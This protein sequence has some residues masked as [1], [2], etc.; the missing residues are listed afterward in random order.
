MFGSGLVWA[1]ENV[2]AGVRGSSNLASL[3]I[4]RICSVILYDS[5]CVY[6][7]HT[8]ELRILRQIVASYMLRLSMIVFSLLCTLNIKDSTLL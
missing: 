7:N 5:R 2:V 8:C 6:D 3:T 1:R 4:G